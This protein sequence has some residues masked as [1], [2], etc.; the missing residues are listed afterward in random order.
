MVYA[1]SQDVV[2]PAWHD[3]I[4]PAPSHE[5][6]ACYGNYLPWWNRYES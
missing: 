2:A 4:L 3:S 6:L 5:E 1:I